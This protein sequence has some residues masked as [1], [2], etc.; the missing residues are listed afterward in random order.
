MFYIRVYLF[1]TCN[2]CSVKYY[3]LFQFN[4]LTCAAKNYMNIEYKYYVEVIFEFNWIPTYLYNMYAF[5]VFILYGTCNLFA[6]NKSYNVN[7]SP[8]IQKLQV[9]CII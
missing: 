3:T 7:Y 1:E 5:Y 6:Y 2:V 4:F 8:H 9:L